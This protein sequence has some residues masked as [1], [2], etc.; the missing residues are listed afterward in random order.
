M[1]EQVRKSEEEFL[2]RGGRDAF[3]EGRRYENYHLAIDVT[4]LLGKNHPQYD[5]NEDN[6]IVCHFAPV[7]R[8][9]QWVF[10]RSRPFDDKNLW[11][12]LAA[13][14][15]LFDQADIRM[16]HIICPNRRQALLRP[17]RLFRDLWR[18][19]GCDCLKMLS[20]QELWL[21]VIVIQRRIAQFGGED[22]SREQG[23]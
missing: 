9:K 17:C 18:N 22:H 23:L 7:I 16:R 5:E 3:M 1:D 14:R 6:D 8:Q 19:S 10:G 2:A 21:E 12:W 13:K 20:I 4:G 15:H 11:I